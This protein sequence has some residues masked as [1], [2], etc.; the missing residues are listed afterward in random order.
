M[1]LQFIDIQKALDKLRGDQSEAIS[2]P[3]IPRVHWEDIGGL[4]HV[5]NVI[6]ETFKLPL[7]HPE[8]FSSGLKKRSGILLFGPPGILF[9]LNLFIIKNRNWK[10]TCCQGC[11]YFLVFEFFICQRTRIV[12]YVYW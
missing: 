6:L 9:I 11:C 5:K 12:E 4:Y 8:L 7:E 10:D 3:K 1:I 2:A